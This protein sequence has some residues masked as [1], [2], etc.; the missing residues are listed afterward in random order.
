M[1][2]QE[3]PKASMQEVVMKK[4]KLI[5]SLI[6]NKAKHDTLF[7]IAVQ[8]YWEKAK[9]KL[10]EKSKTLT[11]S[12]KEL[13]NDIKY[14]LNKIYTKLEQKETLPSSISYHGF[15][16]NSSLNLPYPENHSNDYERAIR[17]M[18]SSIY[19]EVKLSEN[20]YDR[21]VLNNWE[22][23]QSF[24]NNNI[25]YTA[26]TGS[27]IMPTNLTMYSGYAPPLN[28]VYNTA[29]LIYAKEITNNRIKF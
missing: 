21:Y 27:F 17:M 25:Q 24:I 7:E 5:K 3:T 26:M 11:I 13:E 1:N 15:T 4:E 18:Q 12:V 6:E 19:D 29:S 28:K 20:E 16:W 23:K 22:W 8:G 9:E 14:Q 10:E 2:N